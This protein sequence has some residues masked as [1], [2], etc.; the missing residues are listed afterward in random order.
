MHIPILSPLLLS[1]LDAL[2]TLTQQAFYA[3][4]APSSLS[5]V[6]SPSSSTSPSA[7]GQYLLGL[8]TADV[9]GPVVETNLMGYAS[10]AQTGT[11]LHMRQRVRAFIVSEP[12]SLSPSSRTDNSTGRILLLNADIAMGDTGVRRALLA[13][14]A[15]EFGEMYNERNVALVGTHQHSGVGG[16]LENLLPQLTS[17]GLCRSSLDAIVDGALLA[18]RRAHA[19]LAPGTLAA[20]VGRVEGG[21]RNRSPLAYLANPAAERAR[22][23]GEGGEGGDQEWGMS[24]LRFG[25][26]AGELDKERGF[27]SFFGVH[28]TSIY[29]NN[30]LVSADNKGMAA[31]L[32]ET[33]EDP[34]AMP[35]N[36]SYVAGFVQG[37]VGDTSP[38]TCVFRLPSLHLYLFQSHPSPSPHFVAASFCLPFPILL[39]PTPEPP[40]RFLPRARESAPESPRPAWWR[41][42]ILG[43]RGSTPFPLSSFLALDTGSILGARKARRDEGVDCGAPLTCAGGLLRPGL[44]MGGHL[45]TICVR[46]PWPCPLLCVGFREAMQETRLPRA[47]RGRAGLLAAASAFPPGGVDALGLASGSDQ[48]LFSSETAALHAATCVPLPPYS[49]AVLLRSSGVRKARARPTSVSTALAPLPIHI[50][51]DLR[52]LLSGTVGSADLDVLS[53]LGRDFVSASGAGDDFCLYPIFLLFFCVLGGERLDLWAATF[54]HPFSR[55]PF[56]LFLLA[57]LAATSYS[58]C[59]CAPTIC[60]QSRAAQVS[61][62]PGVEA[63]NSAAHLR[64][65][66]LI[67]PRGNFK[68]LGAF[69]ESPGEPYDG[70]PCTA[71][72]STC[73]GTAQ[74]CHGRGPAFSADA[75]GFTSS[76]VIGGRQAGAVRA[77]LRGSGGLNGDSKEMTQ[78]TGS[79]RSAHAYVDM[80]RYEFVLGNGTRVRTCPAAMGYSF[81]GGTTT[82]KL[83]IL[84]G[85]SDGPGA[86]DFVQGD[87]KTSQN[88][89]WEIVKKFVTPAPPAEQIACHYPKPI[90]LNTAYPMPLAFTC[91]TGQASIGRA[92]IE[93]GYAHE[94]YEWSPSTVDVQILKVGNVGELTTM[95]GRRIREAVRAELISSDILGEDAHVVVA[96]PANTYAHY[97]TTREEY[98][99]QRYEGASTLY[100]PYTLEAYIDKYTS[101][102]AFLADGASGTPPSDE[103]P[104]EQISKAIS[105]Q[106]DVKFDAAPIGKH[107]G[108]ISKDVVTSELYHAGDTV[109][110][111]FVGANPRNNLR[112]EGTYLTV[113]R[114]VSRTWEAVRSDS[115]P[116]TIY[117]WVRESTILGTSRVNVSCRYLSD[118]VFWGLE[119]AHWLDFIVRWYFFELYGLVKSD[120]RLRVVSPIFTFSSPS[121]PDRCFVKYQTN[122]QLLRRPR[123]LPR[124]LRPPCGGLGQAGDGVSYGSVLATIQRHFPDANMGLENMGSE[125]SVVVCGVTNLI[126]EMS[127]WEGM[128]GGM[129]MRTWSDALVEMHGR[130]PTVSRKDGVAKGIVRGVSQNTDIGLMTKEFT[131]KIQIISSLKSVCARVYGAGSAEAR[132]A[133][134]VAAHLGYL[135]GVNTP[136][137]ISPMED[138]NKKD[139]KI[140]SIR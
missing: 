108:Q 29:E 138:D 70:L 55:L 46:C 42:S 63:L 113:D 110:A 53:S 122:S 66:V 81:A 69:C 60:F 52:A 125:V 51:S 23:V 133:E 45:D 35:G 43:A 109:F 75:W 41:A 62:A 103:P 24:V 14:L 74:Q 118:Q 111:E 86:F 91:L 96:G 1:P 61:F 54:L 26:G 17:L 124:P 72:S 114:F 71:N 130:L 123:R 94:P 87:N 6:L 126:I 140:R 85:G 20:G 104:A 137:A 82:Q 116:S 68:S 120:S 100:G 49:S 34:T 4:L 32:Y 50:Y 117:R 3:L 16:Y 27:L 98:N 22:Y 73:G 84:A 97:I 79:V 59:G 134:A 40:V 89:F 36:A 67:A 47:W 64:F 88:P 93:C 102:V 129:A 135:C 136:R 132:Q 77:L 2:H 90:L 18:T 83:M 33:A 105:L 106:T 9:T 28:G 101:L 21:S 15:E 107:F 80:S 119:A 10:L 92:E 25:G 131:A 48:D 95:A 99:V 19:S 128:A 13:A 39:L 8:G 65:I 56:P 127:R 12:P 115:H 78:V 30:T 31:Y 44:A 57:T 11:G 58:E 7:D 139:A 37:A 5:S 112:L 38:N 121:A 76:E